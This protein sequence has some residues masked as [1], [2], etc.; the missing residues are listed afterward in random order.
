MKLR[1]DARSDTSKRMFDA[2]NTKK[3]LRVCKMFRE[4][5]KNIRNLQKFI[6]PRPFV[7]FGTHA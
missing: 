2:A 4:V 6:F 5:N 3:T 7:C 1:G